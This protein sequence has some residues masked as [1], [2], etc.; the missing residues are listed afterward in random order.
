[1]TGQ[2]EV[3]HGTTKGGYLEREFEG[4]ALTHDGDLF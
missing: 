3:C 4:H 1:M 2:N